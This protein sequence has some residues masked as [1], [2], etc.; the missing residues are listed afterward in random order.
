M[1]APSRKT[2]LRKMG[3]IKN[4]ESLRKIVKEES[5][6]AKMRGVLHPIVN[7]SNDSKRKN[8]LDI[9]TQFAKKVQS[10]TI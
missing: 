5:L 4:S 9:Q 10:E 8:H 1:A 7:Y 6:L 3:L 2:T